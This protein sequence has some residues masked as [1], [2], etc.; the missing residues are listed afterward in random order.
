MFK[1]QKGVSLPL[2]AFTLAVLA[3]IVGS[4]GAVRVKEARAY[5]GQT[6]GEILDE[7]AKGVELY[8]KVNLQVLIGPMPVTVPGYADPYAPTMTELRAGGFMT[9]PVVLDNADYSVLLNRSPVGCVAPA[10]CSIWAQTSLTNPILDT[11]GRLDA[12]YLNSLSVRVTNASTGFSGP[13]NP[14]V[15]TG[16]QGT[17]TVANPDP[18]T[19]NGIVVMV[20]GLGGSAEPWLQVGDRRNPNFLGPSV[21]GPQFDTP[22]QTPGNACT[23]NG[24]FATGP[25]GIVFCNGGQWTI[26]S[27]PIEVGDTAC[28]VQGA[29]AV[30][31]DGQS[32]LCVNNRWRDH[33]TYGYSSTAY[34][35]HGSTVT[36]PVCGVGLTPVAT[37]SSTSASV[38]IGANN[39]GNNTGSFISNIDAATNM[40]SITGSNGSQA[41]TNARA[42]VLTSC[43]PT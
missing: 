26:Y 15:I 8:R 25:N 16:S 13:P 3:I 35:V 34:Y 22:V 18:A 31:A 39:P 2:M 14:G 27:G 37:I 38:I 36:M 40:V 32:L 9:T 4:L 28:A 33:R 42:L 41:G 19:R 21:T 12:V 17:W 6:R 5:A 24:A 29:F 20:S 10:P 30:Q 23:P 43:V 7:L 11:E 1:N